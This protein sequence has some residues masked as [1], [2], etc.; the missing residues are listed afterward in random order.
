MLIFQLQAP[1]LAQ[2]TPSD[3]LKKVIDCTEEI[4]AS[5]FGYTFGQ[6]TVRSAT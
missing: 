6:S 5:S 1:Y 2:K 3:N 4:H